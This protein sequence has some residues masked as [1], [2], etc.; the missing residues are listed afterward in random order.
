MK[1]KIN[2]PLLRIF[3][4]LAL[5]FIGIAFIMPSKSFAGTYPARWTMYAMNFD[6][7]I[8]LFMKTAAI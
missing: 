6:H 2:L 1:S 3:S 7:N 5:M 8:T 4:I